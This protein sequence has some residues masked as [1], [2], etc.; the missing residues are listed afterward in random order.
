MR[1][2]EGEKIEPE[3][4]EGD[5]HSGSEKME[6]HALRIPRFE[7]E[8]YEFE[9]KVGNIAAVVGKVTRQS[10]TPKRTVSDRIA[11]FGPK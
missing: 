4:D 9:E 10:G 7:D 1:V 8:G 11:A 6:S 2:E 3:V 5:L